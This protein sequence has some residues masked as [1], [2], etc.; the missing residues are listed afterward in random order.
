MWV[1]IPILF[2]HAVIYILICKCFK[3]IY[4]LIN[5]Q[6]FFF[7]FMILLV[8]NGAWLTHIKERLENMQKRCPAYIEFWA[9]NNIYFSLGILLF[10][11]LSF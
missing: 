5:C 4:A 7:W 11:G 10:L 8:L 3:G 2:A 1:D 9:K 6:M